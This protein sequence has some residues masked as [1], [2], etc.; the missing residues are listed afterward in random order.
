M[1][2]FVKDKRA[3]VS[4]YFLIMLVVGIYIAANTLPAAINTWIGNG[5]VL[6]G[7]GA[8]AGFAA[9]QTVN[10]LWVTVGG[11]CIMAVLLMMLLKFGAKR[12]YNFAGS[13][14]HSRFVR[15]TTAKVSVYAL[16]MLTVG[17]YIAANVL[18][19]AINTWLGNGTVIGSGGTANATL[20]PLWVTV[21]SIV[22]LAIVLTTILRFGRGK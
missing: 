7:T 19:S 5:T 16:I 18:P 14:T 11:I 17:I 1:R 9:S 13:I 2:S 20:N 8:S 21:G 15:S 12:S 10:T 3:K 4:V 22:I 6:Y